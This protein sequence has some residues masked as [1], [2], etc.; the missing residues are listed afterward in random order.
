MHHLDLIFLARKSK[1]NRS[2]EVIQKIAIAIP[3]S[4]TKRDLRMDT[5]RMGTTLDINLSNA[6][7]VFISVTFATMCKS[8]APIFLL[9]FAFAFRLESP[10]FKLL[11]IMLMI[12]VGILLTDLRDDKQFFADHPNA[13]P[14]TTAHVKIM[15]YFLV[16]T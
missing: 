15:F 16:A 5:T 1:N 10:R 13:V 11:G 12:S 3:A 6:S 14:I 8:A 2:S 4:L 9:I 7:L